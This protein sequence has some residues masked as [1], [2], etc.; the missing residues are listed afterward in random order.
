MK[1]KIMAMLLSVIMVLAIF[2]S[3]VFASAEAEIVYV[4]TGDEGLCS[5]AWD[6]LDE[7]NKMTVADGIYTKVFDSVEPGDYQF[8]VVRTDYDGILEFI[9]DEKDNNICITV[10]ETSEVT[11]T[12]DE[13]TRKI[14]VT[15]E[16]VSY[17][18]KE[19]I[20]NA[21]YAVGSG[22]GTWLN[23]IEWDHTAE[24][25]R[26][27]EISERVYQ[28][29]Y[30]GVSASDAYEF[31]FAANG[32]W[33]DSWGCGDTAQLES[34]VTYYAE[35]GGQNF[36]LT[37]PEDNSTVTLTLDLSEF[38]Y[39]NG[40]AK[41]T[42][43]VKGPEEEPFYA[44]AGSGEIC[45]SVWGTSDKNNKMTCEDG[46]YT[47]EFPSA[48]P[49][50]YELNVFYNSVEGTKAM[51]ES[52]KFALTK[53]SELTVTYDELTHEITVSADSILFASDYT[54]NEMYIVGN[55][56]GTWLNNSS[57]N[58]AYSENKM[59]EIADNV[60]SIEFSGISASK[61]LLFKFAANGSW[62]MNWGGVDENKDTHSDFPA[63]SG[64]S[65][66][67][68]FIGENIELEIAQDNSTV[69]FTLDLREFDYATKTGAKYLVQVN[70]EIAYKAGDFFVLGGT[71]GIDHTYED[72]TLTI[73]S[74][75]PVSIW[76]KTTKDR[77]LVD[78]GVDANIELWTVSIDLSESEEQMGAF[79]V[80]GTADIKIQADT[81][82]KSGALY[83]GLQ[84]GTG[85]A[86]TISGDRKLTA[87]GGD[88]GAGIGGGNMCG[89]GNITISYGTIVAYGGAYASGIGGGD[90]GGGGKITING[91][92][93]YATGGV[94][95][96]GIGGGQYGDGGSIALSGGRITSIGGDN[97]SV[98]G[99]G[100]GGEAG[101]FSTGTDGSAF[102]YADIIADS[103]DR[104]N[105]NG[106]VFE[107]TSGAVYGSEVA[108]HEYATVPDGCTLTVAVGQ[109]LIIEENASLTNYGTIVNE[110]YLIVSGKFS[111]SGQIIGNDIHYHSFIQE[112]AE[113]QYKAGGNNIYYYSCICG[114]KHDSS[115]FST[116][117]YVL[118]GN[119]NGASYGCDED[120]DNIGIYE[121]VDG[122]L[123]VRFKEDS[124]VGVK[125]TDNAFWYLT[126]GWYGTSTK[127]ELYD[128]AEVGVL[129]DMLYIPGGVTLTL[130]LQANANGSLT[131]SYEPAPKKVYFTNNASWRENIFIYMW[132]TNGYSITWPG[133]CMN[134]EY[135]NEFGE[136]VYSYTVPTHFT[137]IIFNNGSYQ[138][139]DIMN[140]SECGH[141]YISE[142]NENG[143]FD[144]GMFISH[145][146][147][148]KDGCCDAC[149]SSICISG[150]VDGD[151]TLTNSDLTLMI[152]ILSGFDAPADFIEI[153]DM[154]GDG[155]INNRDAIALIAV[156]NKAE[157][158]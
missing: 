79:E 73:L 117:S 141:Y 88:G 142:M 146:D 98:I 37:V 62:A 149:K 52:I 53:S 46:I 91:G 101:S 97:A 93:I 14:E 57:W 90:R 22:N 6:F 82:L 94:S 50:K 96:A 39:E 76:G 114:Q 80:L 134:F 67:A 158:Y 58:P 106:V 99:N 103:D 95:G 70:D 19:V 49:G 104:S 44:V 72:N 11:V 130:E 118:F 34:G 116:A 17:T 9:G 38:T 31:K 132:N 16:H 56:N 140:F 42:A 21:V 78:Y 75:T 8:K 27:T 43:A 66:D 89:G 138:T 123:T 1:K 81:T 77:I 108:I 74:S 110:G 84:V 5:G 41:I 40:G 24:E 122:T 64:H 148:D 87:T 26:M 55:G 59:T 92:M 61:D 151:G 28:I 157:V 45:G 113:E 68:A 119:I 156:L 7:S 124:Y 155:K 65:F 60:Y 15:G 29:E 47:K 4:V 100:K 107:G 3:S 12:F 150:D 136:D 128:A 139:V 112:I 102:I 85:A 20:I 145:T 109:A 137:N 86:V 71:A 144:V 115:V 105:W 120:A 129:G 121:F 111:N 32:S 33:D 13:N 36:I 126:D 131:L 135:T 2:P 154:T 69:K 152:R 153:A 147:S 63:F 25:N 125:T 127:A 83:A 30:I 10:T 35:Y 133:E 143:K 18:V 48:A 23:G 51:G 54:V